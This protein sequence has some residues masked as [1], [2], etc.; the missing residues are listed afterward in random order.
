VSF[1]GGVKAAREIVRHTSNNLARTS[2]ELGGKSPVVV[3]DDADI[4]SAVNGVLAAAFAAGGQ[5]CAAGS[6]LIV[7]HRIAESLVARVAERA[8]RIVVGDPFDSKTEVGPLATRNQ[9][10]NIER[11][12]ARA[13]EQGGRLLVGG[14][15]A[16]IG[17]GWY[18]R[19]TILECHDPGLEILD[20]ELFGPV[21]AV[22][23]FRTEEEAVRL[24]N[25]T[26]Y[27][28]ACGVFT[29]NGARA[30]RMMS[31]I[32]AGIVWINTYRMVSPVAEFGGFK[33]SGYG[34]EGGLQSIHDY[35]QTK[36]VWFSTDETP[37]ADPFGIR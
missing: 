22:M 7:H 15:R 5:S 19:P 21:L 16:E 23:N 10:V 36:T 2:L 35:T 24:A 26:R 34:R 14:A 20:T 13:Q 3:F 29:R 8:E 18:Y 28:L 33:D 31:A 12:V 4:D 11:A 9:L 37:I 25:A 1:T 27:G 30:M 6:R 17:G 32:D